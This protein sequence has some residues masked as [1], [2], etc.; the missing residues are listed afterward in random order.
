MER[1]KARAEQ[2]RQ[3]RQVR[4][5]RTAWQT[6]SGVTWQDLVVACLATAAA[7]GVV[8][9]WSPFWGPAVAAEPVTPQE[10]ARDG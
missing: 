5:L 2:A 9:M 1:V 8:R 6:H 4:V 7:V 3:A 10:R